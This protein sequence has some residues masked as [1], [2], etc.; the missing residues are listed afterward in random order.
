MTEEQ[1]KKGEPGKDGHIVKLEFDY[2]DERGKYN[3]YITLPDELIIDMDWQED[4][5]IE[6]S[7]T[8]NCFDWGDVS[9]VVLRNLTKEQ[10]KD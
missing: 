4:D 7:T 1:P 8:E 3:P 10:R 6:I 5:E 9:S 2:M